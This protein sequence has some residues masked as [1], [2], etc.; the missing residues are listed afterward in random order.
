MVSFVLAELGSGKLKERFQVD[1]R[2]I[3]KDFGLLLDATSS[4]Y[5]LFDSGEALIEEHDLE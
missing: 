4:E 2:M 1:P 5:W 3:Q